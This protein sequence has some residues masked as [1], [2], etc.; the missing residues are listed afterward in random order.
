MLQ[1]S[2]NV[3]FHLMTPVGRFVIV[4]FY[5]YQQIAHQIIIILMAQLAQAKIY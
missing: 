5:A 3:A 1:T 2:I 4:L